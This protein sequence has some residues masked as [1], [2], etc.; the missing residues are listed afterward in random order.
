MKNLSKE[1][2]KIIAYDDPNQSI[3]E[4]LDLEKNIQ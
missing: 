4:L 3:D 2:A 1:L